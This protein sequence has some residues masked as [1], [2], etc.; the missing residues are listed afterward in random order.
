VY[1]GFI[2]AREGG[3]GV[4]FFGVREYQQ[5]DPLR[6]INWRASARHHQS[7]FINEFEQER[8]ADVNIILDTRRRSEFLSDMG[9]SLFEHS[10][11]AAA[12]L[13]D[14]FL[15][16]GNR[17]GLLMF[18]TQL[19]WTVPGYGKIQRERI[20]RSLA[21]ATPGES[22]I[23]QKLENIPVRFLPAYSQLVLISPLHKDDVSILIH[24]RVRGY[25]LLVISPDPIAFEMKHASK[26]D[27]TMLV[28][29]RLARLERLLAILKLRQAGIQVLNWD[30]DSSL[31]GTIHVALSRVIP[32]I[33]A[34]GVGV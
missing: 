20:L 30:V 1:S 2:P 22:L 6:W 28:A 17:V 33:H 3:P 16:D 19:D 34:I 7:V 29:A 23:F 31:D 21:R 26:L 14:T 25:A 12:T 9:E 4:E 24:L 32:Q 27:A 18:G 5:G 10:V 11:G 13:S 15:K 8:C